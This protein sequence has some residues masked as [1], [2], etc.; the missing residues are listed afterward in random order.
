MAGER[1]ST[2]SWASMLFVVVV[3][4]ALC[5]PRMA[6]GMA[7]TDSLSPSQCRDE[8]QLG[9]DACKNVLFGNPPSAACCVRI[10]VSHFECVCP[11]IDAKLAA[12]VTVARAVKLFKDCGRSVPH[13]F[14]CG[15]LY[16]P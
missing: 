12:L 2:Y 13:K 16:F 10:R 6:W 8:R 11:V 1:R 5:G 15:S 14:H 4:V 3:V 9:V 7:Q